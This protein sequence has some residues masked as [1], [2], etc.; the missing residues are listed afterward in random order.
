M[1]QPQSTYGRFFQLGY[2]TRDIEHGI[3]DVKRRMGAQ[4]IDLI[5][6]VRDAEGAETPLLR[7]AH[8][9]LPGVEVEL[10]QPRLDRD[11]IYLDMLPPEGDPTAKLHHLAF[12]VPDE[13]AWEAAVADF[14]V[15]DT[16]IALEF[17]TPRIW[18]AYFDTRCETGHY[19][20]LVLRF[21][22]EDERL[23]R[24]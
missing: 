18:C 6:D 20:E 24:T 17:R 4:Q 14:A 19:S 13:A 10:I 7:L 3:A 1:S 21:F 11:S 2:V 23:W 8:L 9:V 22:P 12:A 15:M 5:D 16:P